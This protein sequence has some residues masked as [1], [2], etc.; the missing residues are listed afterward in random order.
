MAMLWLGAAVLLTL[1]SGFL[2]GQEPGLAFVTAVLVLWAAAAA[3]VVAAI[4]P[5]RAASGNRAQPVDDGRHH[6]TREPLTTSCIPGRD[7]GRTITT[8]WLGGVGAIGLVAVVGPGWRAARSRALRRP[9]VT[10]VRPR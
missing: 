6:R 1:L 5:A 9:N 8:A 3:Y 2:L 10:E 4:W 7:A